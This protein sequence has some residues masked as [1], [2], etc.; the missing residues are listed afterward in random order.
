M[1][2]LDDISSPTVFAV[3]SMLQDTK[4]AIT[5]DETFL[6]LAILFVMLEPISSFK[7]IKMLIL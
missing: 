5:F 6:R 7:Y 4:T 1:F 3:F 2:S